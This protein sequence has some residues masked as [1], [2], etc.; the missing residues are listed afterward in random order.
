MGVGHR[1]H[2]SAQGASPALTECW[3]GHEAMVPH[4]GHAQLDWC[5]TERT[6][7]LYCSA[8]L[9]SGPLRT[10][11][12]MQPPLCRAT[13]CNCFAC[14]MHSVTCSRACLAHN[15]RDSPRSAVCGHPVWSHSSCVCRRLWGSTAPLRTTLRWTEPCGQRSP[16]SGV[17]T[18]AASLVAAPGGCRLHHIPYTL[19]TPASSHLPPGKS[20]VK[21]RP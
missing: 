11:C 5:V 1:L 15:A 8:W 13:A 2:L 10:A 19:R 12:L 6:G 17:P 18:T 21:A 16:S 9:C 3:T 14:C 7:R 4:P 20:R